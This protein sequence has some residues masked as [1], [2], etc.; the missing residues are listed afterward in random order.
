ML[1]FILVT[2]YFMILRSLTICLRG[3][4]AKRKDKYSP[5]VT[6]QIDPFDENDVYIYAFAN[7]VSLFIQWDFSELIF[8][9]TSHLNHQINKVNSKSS[10]IFN[11]TYFVY[12]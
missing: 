8:V 5:C 4:Y 7:V 6:N 2:L 10:N 12:M 3:R 9:P 11:C 1:Y